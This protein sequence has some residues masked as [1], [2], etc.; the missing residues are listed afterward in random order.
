MEQLTKRPEE[1][2]DWIE[3]CKLLQKIELTLSKDQIKSLILIIAHYFIHSNRQTIE[4]LS[5]TYTLFRLYDKKLRPL[6][7]SMKSKFKIKIDIT[8]ATALN[9]ILMHMKWDQWG[10]YERSLSKAIIGEINRQTV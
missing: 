6:L 4:E 9:H 1:I 5:I 8:T 10:D 2:V 7:L 3:I